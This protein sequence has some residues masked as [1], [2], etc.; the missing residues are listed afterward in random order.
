MPGDLP[1]GEAVPV[2]GRL[3]AGVGVSSA[4][5]FGVYVHVPFCASRCGYC[6]FNTYVPSEVAGAHPFESYVAAARR[7]IALAGEVLPAPVPPA[8]TV[9][10]GGGT[11]TLLP[12]HE[13]AALLDAVRAEFGLS[14]DAEVTTEANPESVTRAGLA[15]LRAAGFTRISL[16]MQSDLPHVLAVLD[17]RH[18]PGRAAAAAREA[19]DAGFKH[20]SLDLIYG[21]PGETDADW[22]TSLDA[23]L[24]AQ[25]DHLSCY[26]LVV[27][28]GTAMAR[29]VRAGHLPA[30]DEDALA[31]RY[32]IAEETLSA[33]GMTW[34]EVSNWSRTD[35]DRCRHNLL[36]WHSGDWWGV[37]PGAH[38]HVGG[39]RWWN[40]RRPETYARLLAEGRSPAADREVLD[41]PARRREDVMLRVR[42]REGLDLTALPERVRLLA[43]AWVRDGLADGAASGEGRLVLTVRGRL[44]ADLVVR[45]LWDALG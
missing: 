4:E 24:R 35:A 19:R 25:P 38:S 8:S 36:Y 15:E 43:D 12:P 16:G 22:R 27:E 11:P 28:D 10:F 18:T 2:D 41:T 33:A 23:A 30:V 39:V 37:G 34:Y 6:D 14:A 7:E 20:V 42:L 21:T 13:L 45:E 44:L 17:R 9:F 29:R 3:P 31:A 5:G 26:A 40:V 32:A 1:S